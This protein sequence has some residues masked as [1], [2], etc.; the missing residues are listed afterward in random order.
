MVVNREYTQQWNGKIFSHRLI[1]LQLRLMWKLGRYQ[2]KRIVKVRSI[3]M[4][5]RGPRF[6]A[7]KLNWLF[8][9]ERICKAYLTK[10]GFRVFGFCPAGSTCKVDLSFGK[11]GVELEYVSSA[12]N[13]PDETRLYPSS[14]CLDVTRP[15]SGVPDGIP[16][17]GI[18][19]L[20]LFN[21]A[22]FSDVLGYS[23]VIVIGDVSHKP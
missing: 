19:S 9:L 15:C 7:L 12:L 5:Y 6:V 16:E 2:V 13:Q 1:K 8:Y 14:F 20:L 22:N 3:Q 23:E 18:R 21:E 10:S 17:G 11:R 4:R